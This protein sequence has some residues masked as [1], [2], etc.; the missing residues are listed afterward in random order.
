MYADNIPRMREIMCFLGSPLADFSTS[1][2][3]KS[4]RPLSYIF[5]EYRTSPPSKR[6]LISFSFVGRR[7]TKDQTS[8]IFQPDAYEVNK[9]QTLVVFN[10]I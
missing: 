4:R 1:V 7:C 3:A 8:T 5:N 10:V 9:T 2:T 6:Y